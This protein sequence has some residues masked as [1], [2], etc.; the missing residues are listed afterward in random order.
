MTARRV[1]RRREFKTIHIA[2]GRRARL[3]CAYLT[4]LPPRTIGHH[5]W[6]R[7]LPTEEG[8][9]A[10]HAAVDPSCDA[11]D[12]QLPEGFGQNRLQHRFGQFL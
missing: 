11:P 7:I 8:L 12:C 6:L 1:V 3:V 5:I 4:I 2:A 9:T 10:I